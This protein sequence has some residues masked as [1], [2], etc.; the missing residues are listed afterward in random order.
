MNIFWYIAPFVSFLGMLSVFPSVFPHFW[1]KNDR[2]LIAC[3]IVLMCGI[4][5]CDLG[6]GKATYCI[7]E[8]FFHNFLPFILGIAGFY[9]LL[10]H[11]KISLHV[12]PTP[13]INTALLG[14]S[15]ILAGFLST[16]GACVL[17]IRPLLA[18]NRDRREK[19]HTLIFFI[20][21]VC[22][23]GGC[24]SSFGDPPLL[25]GFLKG[26]PFLWPTLTLWRPFLAMSAALLPL[27]WVIDSFFYRQEAAKQKAEIEV[28]DTKHAAIQQDQI[29]VNSLPET[30]FHI[31]GLSYIFLSLGIPILF[32]VSDFFSD[33]WGGKKLLWP[34]SSCIRD[35]ILVGSL[36]FI[37][38]YKKKHIFWQPIQEVT[39]VFAALF[40]MVE[41][42]LLFLQKSS[43]LTTVISGPKM[44]MKI[45]WISGIMSSVLDNAPTYLLFF[46]EAIR[47]NILEA[48]AT[49]CVFMGALTYIGNSPN[50]LVKSIA[51]NSGIRMPSFLSYCGI[52]FLIL[53]PLLFTYSYLM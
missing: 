14:V 33:H 4:H 32:M 7:A 29:K 15:S 5:F 21:L 23:I 28:P 24:L 44:S 51:E 30:R 48:L 27:Y 43:W 2:A 1:H 42:L 25:V 6:I 53:G 16:T 17:M 41:P 35:L 45:F 39:F 49:G 38:I 20:F 47:Q 52:S 18:I 40:L 12:N 26:V 34:L 11:V 10:S 8:I 31:E 36:L 9:I 13:L 46:Q 37:L 22:N 50:L 19:R 3:F